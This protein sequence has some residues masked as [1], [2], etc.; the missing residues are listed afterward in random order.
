MSQAAPAWAACM[1]EDVRAIKE[2]LPKIVK[3]EQVVNSISLKMSEFETKL[4]CVETRVDSVE[5]SCTFISDAYENQKCE[6]KKSQTL[7]SNLEK[8]CAEMRINIKQHI[9][10]ADKM[11][12]K[13]LDLESR[14]MRENLIFYG[15]SEQPQ[16]LEEDTDTETHEVMDDQ[17]NDHREQQP[18]RQVNAVPSCEKLVKHFIKNVLEIDPSEIRFDRAHRL[19]SATARKPRP[20]VVKFHSYTDRERIRQKSFDDAIKEK[21]KHLRQGVGIQQPGPIREA[22]KALQPAAKEAQDNRQTTRIIGNKLFV[23]NILKKK[24]VDGKVIDHVEISDQ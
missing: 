10:N 5:T 21:M 13:L 17:Q 23:N 16:V 1:I 7:V 15:I 22:R 20:I 4:K 11:N 9:Q 3:I 19:G 2:A 14:S 18:D 24:Y 6:L 12:D 8:S